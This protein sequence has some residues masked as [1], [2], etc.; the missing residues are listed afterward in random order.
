MEEPLRQIA[1]NAGYEGSVVVEN[2]K[3]GR[4]LWLQRQSARTKT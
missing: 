4:A 2:V 3:N 1:N